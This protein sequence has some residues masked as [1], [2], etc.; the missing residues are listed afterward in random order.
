LAATIIEIKS[1]E[2]SGV[3]KYSMIKFVD[4]NSNISTVIL[5]NPL[6]KGS[7]LKI[8]GL[9]K[10]ENLEIN[11]YNSTG[12]KIDINYKNLNNEL[13]FE[14][15]NLTAGIYYIEILNGTEKT[16]FQFYCD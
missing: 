5:P 6:V 16:N 11:I 13:I 8:I 14:T 7:E 15:S 3:T 1:V 4:F 9:E 10:N 2:N 12:K